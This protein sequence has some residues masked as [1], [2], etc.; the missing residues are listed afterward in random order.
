MPTV[1]YDNRVVNTALG[2]LTGGGDLSS[3]RVLGLAN[4]ASVTPGTYGNNTHYSKIS[5]DKKG[6]VTNAISLPFS[7]TNF[8]NITLESPSIIG[9]ITKNGKWVTPYILAGADHDC[10][11]V[12]GDDQTLKF[13]NAIIEA[14]ATGRELYCEPGYYD[15]YANAFITISTS[16]VQIRGAGR[17]STYIR[18]LSVSG[19]TLTFSGQFPAV[20]D[21]TFWP[22]AYKT[23]GAEIGLHQTYQGTV[24]NCLFQYH[25][26]AVDIFNCATPEI[27]SS[28]ALFCHGTENIKMSGNS[29]VGCYGTLLDNL[30]FN[31]A[32]PLAWDLYNAWGTNKLFT[33]GQTTYENGWIWQCVVTG[34]TASSGT[35]TPDL[36]NSYN[37]TLNNVVHGGAQFRAIESVF[38]TSILQESYAHSLSM[39]AVACLNS[40]YGY[41]MADTAA[42][43]TSFPMWMDAVQFVSDH[44]YFGGLYADGGADINLGT[45]TWIGST[46]KGSGIY[47]TS[48]FKGPFK[49][50]N[51]RVMGNANYGMVQGAGTNFHVS[52]NVFAANGYE[53]LG[54][55]NDI[56]IGPNLND[57]DYSHNR[58]GE[59]NGLGTNYAAYGIY[60]ADGTS[61]NYIM[62]FNRGKGL[63]QTVVYDG[64]TGANK[65]VYQNLNF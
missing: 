4:V 63:S 45:G 61:N 3:N 52:Y 41:R 24:K 23:S 2:E 46:L 22:L 39:R 58:F 56:F 55:F 42:T 5:V 49:L 18:N 15:V 34:T 13:A 37:W 35:L 29:A 17:N 62:A 20:S 50:N 48:L 1:V 57:F 53:S 43:G 14:N 36:T 28:I 40:A 59:E 30:F 26:R 11:G 47:T 33:A 25:N 51:A 12:S 7:N 54:A 60:L 65:Y 31:N 16:G 6:R 8:A 27:E 64:G 10:S 9:R 19:N 38:L 44:A 21:I 32:Y